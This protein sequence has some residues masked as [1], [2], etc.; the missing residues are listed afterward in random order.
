MKP[1][2]TTSAVTSAEDTVATLQQQIRRLEQEKAEL[3]LKLAW[4][5]EKFRLSQQKRFGAS[6]ERTNSEG[7]QL[8]LFDEPELV[9]SSTAGSATFS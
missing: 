6:S 7:E 1:T 2:P 3:A 5:E 9:G 8:R 4:Y